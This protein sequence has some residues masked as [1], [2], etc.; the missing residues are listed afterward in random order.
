MPYTTMSTPFVRKTPTE[1]QLNIVYIF[2][3][4]VF[5][6]L[7]HF[8]V[9]I[10]TAIVIL[11]YNNIQITAPSVVF[12]LSRIWSFAW[13][14]NNMDKFAVTPCNEYLSMRG[15]WKKNH[16][17]QLN[18]SISMLWSSSVVIK[19]TT[20]MCT[21]WLWC[22]HWN[23]SKTWVNVCHRTLDSSQNPTTQIN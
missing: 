13:W 7:N 3:D 21:S 5:N 12:K 22:A 17:F 23:H 15:F 9:N 20:K 14:E 11:I 6:K 8:L 19:W 1:Q 2:A 16:W 10:D 18:V 4:L